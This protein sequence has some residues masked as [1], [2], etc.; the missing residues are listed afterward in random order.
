MKWEDT[1]LS[2]EM[3]KQQVELLVGQIADGTFF[4]VE[5]GTTIEMPVRDFLGDWVEQQKRNLAFQAE[6]SFKAGQRSVVEWIGD[7]AYEAYD[8]AGDEIRV[9]ELVDWQAKLKEWGI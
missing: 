2:D 9:L 6:V 8:G 1:V 3:V 7:N 4:G 5:K